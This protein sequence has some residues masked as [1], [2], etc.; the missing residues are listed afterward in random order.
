MDWFEYSCCGHTFSKVVR[1]PA[2][3]CVCPR[4]QRP[5]KPLVSVRVKRPGQ[6]PDGRGNDRFCC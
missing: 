6:D 5:V 3:E 1:A 2:T 4:C